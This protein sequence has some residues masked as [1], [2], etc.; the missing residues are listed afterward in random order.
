MD[1]EGANKATRIGTECAMT[2][3]GADENAERPDP[4]RGGGGTARALEPSH[5]TDRACN[6]TTDCRAG[7]NAWMAY[8]EPPFTHPYVR[9][10][11]GK[12]EEV[13]PQ[14]MTEI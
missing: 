13:P 12:A 1:G 8:L 9:C 3:A 4:N 2:E 7:T 11:G 10:C 14:P 5:R 6:E